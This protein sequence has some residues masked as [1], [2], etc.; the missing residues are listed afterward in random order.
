MSKGAIGTVLTLAVIAGLGW[1][2]VSTYNSYLGTNPDSPEGLY[3]FQVE[4]GDSFNTIGDEL[5]EADVA[6][7]NFNQGSRFYKKDTL[8]RG[9]YTLVLPATTEEIIEQINDQA[10]IRGQEVSNNQRKFKQVTIRE[11]LTLQQVADTLEEEGVLGDKE[12]FLSKATNPGLYNYDFLPSPLDCE[13][14]NRSNCVL[15]YLEGY[16]YP[17]TYEFFEDS[18]PDEIIVKMLDNF[19]TKVWSKYGSAI[20]KSEFDKAIIMGSMIEAETGRS[21]AIPGEDPDALNQERR[22]VASVFYNRTEVGMEWKSDP[23]VNYGLPNKVCQQTVNIPDCIF[24]DDRRAQTKYNTYTNKG[25]PIGPVSSPQIEN[26]EAALNPADS[27]YL[28]FVADN[29][30]V[31]IFAET[32]EGHFANIEKVQQINAGLSQ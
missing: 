1:L 13:Y 20:P 30:G 24:L 6:P 17:D 23:T 15:Y 4:D 32:G 31:T 16:L 2:G 12:D 14:G 25:Y 5:V 19:N 8:F 22:N 18:N 10:K 29:R 3:T 9:E 21:A 27:D 28:F 11:G 7:K 26:I